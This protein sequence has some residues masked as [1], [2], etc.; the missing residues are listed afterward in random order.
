MPE[1]TRLSRLLRES[2]A[3]LLD[4]DGPIC[5][6][7]AGRPAS[8]VAFRLRAF[9]EQENVRVPPR[10]AGGSDPLEVLRWVSAAHPGLTPRVEDRLRAEEAAAVQ[11]AAPTSGAT[12]VIAAARRAGMAV[13]VVSNN[14]EPAISSYLSRQG[15][16]RDVDVVVGRAYSD[17][18]L[19]K[20][21]PAPVR[22]AVAALDVSPAACV[23]VGDSRSDIEAARA[24]QVTGVGFAKSPDR[25]RRLVEAGAAV[26]VGA[27]RE[28][29]D[30]FQE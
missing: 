20:P 14:A 25:R 9:L 2:V 27:M 23:L 5:S 28:L 29:A 4:F 12:R 8:M 24:A 30:V 18:D 7:F 11:T 15:L 16:A 1:K 26:V 22:K 21:N 19:M 13:A 6:V 17:P 3:L 10:L